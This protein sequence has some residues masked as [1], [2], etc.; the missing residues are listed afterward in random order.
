MKNFKKALSVLLVTVMLLTAAPLSGF[1]GLEWP[2]LN[3]PEWNLPDFDFNLSA[4]AAEVVNSG[5]CGENLTWTLDS[6]GVLTISG[7]GKMTNY[8]SSYYSIPWSSNRSAIKT[9]IIENGVTS[10]GNYA[11]YYCKSLTSVTIGNSV[12][13]IGYSAFRYCTSLTSVT[14]PDSVTSIGNYAFSYCTNL[15]SITI[16]NPACEIY[17]RADTID[18]GTTIYGYANSTAQAYAEKYNRTFVALDEP[19]SPKIIASG[20]CGEN[21]TWTLDDEGT[22]TISGSGAMPDYNKTDNTAP[23]YSY[24]DSIKKVVVEN[25]VTNIGSYAFF[26]CTS[27]ASVDFGENSQLTSIDSDAFRYC[28]SLTSVVI[29]NSVT[30]IGERAFNGCRGLTSVVIPNSVTSIGDEAF[31]NCSSL[32]IV[33]NLSSLKISKGSSDYGCVGKYAD[34]VINDPNGEVTPKSWTD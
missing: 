27:L 2:E 12:T 14:I 33:I 10:I 25:G 1:V 9:V 29:P 6:D 7:T 22:L 24:R 20:T 26:Y 30:S 34:K 15:A 8:S 13:S 5:T 19:V 17:D 28:T 3:L 11:F 21:L 31:D 4:D 18:A 32:K 16:L 23:W